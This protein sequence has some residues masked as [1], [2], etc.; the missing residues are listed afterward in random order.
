VASYNRVILIGNVTR[1]I[2]L[3]HVGSGTA[4]TDLGIA[5]NERIKK[6]E[7]WVDDTTFVDCTLW[8]RT[9][10]VAS[11]Y[12]SKG[13]PVMIEGKLRFEQWEKDG[14][15][16]S[17]LKV[18]GERLQLLTK[19]PTDSAPPQRTEQRRSTDQPTPDDDAPF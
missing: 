18:V 5:I 6:G 8:G 10:E 2:E 19:K 7:D 3:R 16:H 13:S 4:V 15:K 1:D 12:L 17:R 14:Q 9:A 11:E